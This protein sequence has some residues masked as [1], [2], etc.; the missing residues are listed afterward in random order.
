MF[1]GTFKFGVP[2]K[3]NIQPQPLVIGPL[4]FTFI[5]RITTTSQQLP[6]GV[7]VKE[8]L[9]QVLFTRL[10][11]GFA[12]LVLPIQLLPPILDPNTLH[13]IMSQL[14]HMEPVDNQ[15]GIDRKSTRLNSSHVAISY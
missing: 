7:S 11:G 3:S 4:V 2:L 6:G 9:G 1:I 12:R 13:D 8:L 10:A 14:P 5:E 15:P